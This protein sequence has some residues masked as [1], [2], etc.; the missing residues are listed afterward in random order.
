M[1][2]MQA[3]LPETHFI[4]LIRDGRDVA[5]SV[6]DVRHVSNS[7]AE[8]AER[9]MSRIVSARQ[10][11]RGLAFYMEVRYENLVL[12]SESVLRQICEFVE[13]P[14]DARMLEYFST[15]EERLEELVYR[16]R[17]AAA[18]RRGAAVQARLDPSPARRWPHRPLALRD[19]PR[20]SRRLRPCRGL[21]IR[22]LGYE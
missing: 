6:R 5:L 13:L 22:E 1:T 7:V 9:W 14:W 20:R 3:T 18:K 17:R 4:H 19:E 16:R 12:D 2:L 8:S 21:L 15:A 11:A 10:Q